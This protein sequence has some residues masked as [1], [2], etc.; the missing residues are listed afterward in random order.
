MPDGVSA[1]YI[2]SSSVFDFPVGTILIKNFS[3]DDVLP[4]MISKNIE[5]RLMIKKKVAGYL[6]TIYGMK[7][8]QM[9][10][11]VLTEVW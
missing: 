2:S 1:E 10:L 11:L 3:Y 5:T 8:K 7:I 6:P 9:L 4:E